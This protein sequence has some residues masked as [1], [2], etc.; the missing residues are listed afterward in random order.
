MG[1]SKRYVI[2]A[3]IVSIA[4]VMT[5]VAIMP[6][7]SQTSTSSTGLNALG[8]VT[9]TVFNAD[10]N[11]VGYRQTDNFVVNDGLNDI[12][13]FLFGGG[14]SGNYHWLAL[15]GTGT[16]RD[17]SVCPN[18]MAADRANGDD[19]GSS[20]PKA[21]TTT[22]TTIDVFS[23]TISHTTA[24]NGAT[25]STLALFDTQTVAGSAMFSEATFAP[26]IT[27]FPGTDVLA[28]YTINIGGG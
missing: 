13:A 18:E 5:F 27:V 21:G 10:G 20:T 15:C 26:F 12:Q 14:G 19:F 23:A 24:D 7:L 6:A 1:N 11:I 8:H 25:F 9:L 16:A 2:G 22:S 4:V 3:S 28:T 17:D